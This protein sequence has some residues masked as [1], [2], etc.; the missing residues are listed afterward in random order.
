MDQGG[1]VGLPLAQRGHEQRDAL[2]A[3]IKVG[4]KPAGLH[5]V[6]E[7]PRGGGDEPGV[8]G[9][10]LGAADPH[11]LVVLE[12]A[13]QFR[14]HSEGKLADLVE[15]ERA[16]VG[17]LELA[18]GLLGRPREGALL[19]AE[20]LALEERFGHGGAVD[21]HEGPPAPGRQVVYPSGEHLFAGAALADEREGDF[22]RGDDVQHALEFAHRRRARDRLKDYVNLS[23][24][25]H[26]HQNHDAFLSSLR[27]AP[28]F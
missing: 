21:R 26:E 12:K 1:E 5:L 15:K 23:F 9:D 10:L 18:P 25:A 24:L 16:V 6:V 3:I 17:R 4:P 2:D 13:Q 14:L 8:D 27:G 20:E 7:R 28:V 22:F 11:E 19:V